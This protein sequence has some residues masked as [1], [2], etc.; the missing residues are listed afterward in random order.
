MREVAFAPI[1][2]DMEAHRRPGP[3]DALP[4][5]RGLPTRRADPRRF[6]VQGP[7]LRTVDALLEPV[8][9]ASVPTEVRLCRRV[10]SGPLSC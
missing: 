7:P 6:T 8:L 10:C 1:Q 5:D 2:E 9:S 3:E 4:A